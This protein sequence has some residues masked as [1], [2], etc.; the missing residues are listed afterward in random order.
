M[1]ALDY[2]LNGLEAELQLE[3][4]LGVRLV[5]C[6]RSVLETVVVSEP[7]ESVKN[8]A[9]TNLNSVN[10]ASYAKDNS[11]SQALVKPS[12]PASAQ[13]ETRASNEYF[14]FVFLHERPLSPKGAEMISKITAALKTTLQLAPVVYSGP[15]PEA[16]IYV[17]LGA[18][19]LRKW[20]PALK[21][22]PGM[23]IKDQADHDILVTYSPEYILRFGTIT[24]TVEKI[25]KDMWTSLKAVAQRA[26]QK[27]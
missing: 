10:S 3:R 8:I 6:D 19:A 26:A 11:S 1:T 7:K 4:E 23:W 12:V 17:V 16:K 27:K 5:E 9:E 2:I 25:K 20:F 21:G 24:P 18:F 22:A 15:L 14:D 13:Q